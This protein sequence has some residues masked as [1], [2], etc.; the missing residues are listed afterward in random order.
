MNANETRTLWISVAAGLFAVVLFYSYTQEKKAEY[1]KRYG[2]FK[3]IVIAAEDISEMETLTDS[4]VEV[5]RRPAD[6]IEPDALYEPELAVGQV[7]AAPIKKGEQILQTKL[8]TPGPYTGISIQVSPNKRAVTIPIDE[9]RGVGKLIRPGDRIDLIAALDFG[10]GPNKQKEVKT[11][12]QDV[13]VLATGVK[14]VNN[15]PRLFEVDASGKNVSRVNLNG[16]TTF[17][18]ITVEATPQQAQDLIFIL[19]TA[20]GSLYTSL[21]NPNDRLL[22]RLP[23]STIDSVL[24]RVN[25][26]ML[27]N[28]VTPP[29][30]PPMPA[31]V[32]PVQTRK[33]RNGNFEEL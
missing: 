26:E 7:A 1:D 9:I 24:G 33:K 3:S 27:R 30:P 22:G 12:M 15:I 8:L 6:F 16:D 17:N 14:V 18:S 20:P 19:S 29:A 4:K 13:V 28:R 11:I 5:V 10:S 31:P 32:A 21:R 25:T 2:A 23:S